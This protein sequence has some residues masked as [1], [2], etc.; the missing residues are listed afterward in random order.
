[1]KQKSDPLWKA[2]RQHLPS[3]RMAYEMHADKRP[4]VLFDI[5]EQMVYVY[6][7]VDFKN[8]LNESSQL[9]LCDQ[10]AQSE[11]SHQVVVFVRDNIRRKLVSYT[12]ARG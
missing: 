5:Q 2:V 12:I 8:D 3:V 6:P 10:Y 1:M 11:R 9:A 4:V 7:Y